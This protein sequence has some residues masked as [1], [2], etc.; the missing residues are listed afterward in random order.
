MRT[1]GTAVALGLFDGVHL[2]H[3]AVL[4][5]AAAQA[6]NGLVPAAFTFQPGLS[7]AKGA[8]GF[9]YP[10]SL[11]EQLLR[12]ACGMEQIF[13]PDF[14]ELSGLSGEAFVREVLCGTLHAAYAVCGRDFRFGKGAACGAADLVRFCASSG[15]AVEIVGDVESDG[16]K[17]SS[18]RI[19]TLLE[20]G[21]IAAANTLLGAPYRLQGEIV[22]GAHLGH[23]IG[24]ATINQSFEPGQLVPRFGV[25]A[26]E[27]CTPDGWRLS[28]TNIGVKPTVGYTGLPLAETHILD[29][30]GDLYGQVLEVVL[31]DFLRGE[32]K[33]DS[34]ETL[35]L[36]L[37]S[38]I[39]ARRQLSG[40]YHRLYT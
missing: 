10:E 11:K 5:A 13:A 2:G 1:L 22:H 7:A 35:Q 32:Q 23:T 21:E 24:F 8:Q 31:T 34:L 40:N 25:Y 26:S 14:Q 16:G 20:T 28:V 36:Q 17:V 3:R 33:F 30:S 37:D 18:S 6:A 4:A 38:D 27:T 19:R 9:L 12:E 29:F 39:T 15:I